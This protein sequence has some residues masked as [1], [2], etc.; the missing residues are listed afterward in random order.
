MRFMNSDRLYS[1]HSNPNGGSGGDGNQDD[2]PQV[3]QG[4]SNLLQRQ[5][6]DTSVVAWMLYNENHQHRQANSDLRTQVQQ[7]QS[8]IQT[9]QGQLPGEGAVVLT[10]DHA[11]TWTQYQALGTPEELS[12]QRDNFSRLQRSITLRDAADLHGYKTSVL[13]TLV[14]RDGVTVEVRDGEGDNGRSAFV[15][16][17]EGEADVALPA[18]VSQHWQDFAPSL[19]SEQRSGTRFFR[20]STSGGQSPA[21]AIQAELDRRYANP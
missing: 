3:N 17:S 16:T 11:Q 18:Y 10:G 2:D 21:S 6:N 14:A 19:S 5:N 8:Q 9:L 12:G 7:L 15:V 13:E 1:P 4:Y 20:Q